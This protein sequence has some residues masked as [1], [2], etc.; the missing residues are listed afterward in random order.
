MGYRDIMAPGIKELM[1]HPGDQGGSSDGNPADAAPTAISGPR[2]I[3]PLIGRIVAGNFRVLKLIGVG[4]MGHV[5]QAEQMSLGKMVAIKLLRNELMADEKLIKRFELEAKNASS[6]NHPNSIQIIDFGRDR[7]VLFIA[8]ELL[9]GVDLGQ[10][11]MREGPLPMTRIGRIVDQVLAALDEA[12][13][14][15][16]IH[17]DLKPG[18]VMLVSRRGD[19]DFVK[20][21]DFGIAKCQTSREGVGLTMKGLVC[22]T[23]EYMSP[24]QAR[25]EEVDGRSDLYAVGV[26]LYQLVTGELPFTASSPVGILSKHLAE[27]PQPPSL[28]KPGLAIPRAVEN[29]VLRALAKSPDDRPQTADEMR[30]EL[31]RALADAGEWLTAPAT[32]VMTPSVS[33]SKNLPRQSA[34]FST[35][36]SSSKDRL[37]AAVAVSATAVSPATAAT[38]RRRRLVWVTMG[39]TA[40]L[41]VG[42]F[43]WA[44]RMGLLPAQLAGVTSPP[45]EGP[46]PSPPPPVEAVA[47]GTL[48]GQTAA[49]AP[50][51]AATTPAPAAEEPAAGSAPAA[52]APLVAEAQA[53]S[54]PAA[55][56]AP[57]APP[58]TK[59]PARDLAKRVRRQALAA[60]PRTA[61]SKHRPLAAGA[62]DGQSEP[63]AEAPSPAPGAVAPA[64]PAPSPDSPKP[65]P[66]SVSPP[67]DLM[68][69]AEKLLGQGEVASA[70]KKGEE[71]RRMNPKLPSIYKFLGKCYMR[72]D[73]FDRAKENYRKYLEL[74]PEASD[75][76][77]IK[78]IVK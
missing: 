46:A 3:D 39:L 22:G 16:I 37:P 53:P 8:M 18:N 25:G 76:A 68:K 11:I 34:P 74:A 41:T 59:G 58:E 19:A 62:P 65:S 40:A 66:P 5:Y 75:A 24:E 69:E 64:A 15:G 17:R 42:G 14:S 23:P 70:C 54:E 6:L 63:A 30:Q 51:P 43:L 12:H 29:V 50:P 45:A 52:A 73:Q 7:D 31:Q 27:Q 10:L 13:A 57:A 55:D 33:S 36:P 26:I 2:A 71:Q 60:P 38:S 28:R 78:S 49:P 67:S 56:P 61:P 1:A 9:R 47:T 44:K 77:F 48:P 72:A 20:V 32:P 35:H 4:A 21:C